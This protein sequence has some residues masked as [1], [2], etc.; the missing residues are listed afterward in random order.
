MKLSKL[1]LACGLLSLVAAG[2]ISNRGGTPGDGIFGN[3]VE[4]QSGPKAIVH[5]NPTQGHKANGIVT[6]TT[7]TNGVRVQAG[8]MGL[9]PGTHAFH[10]HEIGD[11]S[12]PD[13]SSAGPHFNPTGTP[14]GGPESAHR[15]LGDLGNFTA[16]ANGEAHLDF[17]DSHLS[18]TGTN[19]IIG[20]SLIVH[21]GADDYTTQP[22]GNSGPRIACGVI[23]KQ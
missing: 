23:Q 9:D 18:L 1:A 16:D 6:F 22:A 17:I 12:A 4:Q 20:R 2:C 15:H 3:Q 5:L 8:L 10:V 7:V 21:A 14:H 19:S 11:C 13:A